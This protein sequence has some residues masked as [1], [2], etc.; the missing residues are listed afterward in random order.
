MKYPDTQILNGNG[1]L[2]GTTYTYGYDGRGR[3]VSLV[4]NQPSP[5][6]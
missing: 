3:P 6:T 4:D 2:T 5:T 1:T